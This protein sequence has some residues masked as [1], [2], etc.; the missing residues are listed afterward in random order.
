[1]KRSNAVNFESCVKDDKG[2]LVVGKPITESLHIEDIVS[3]FKTNKILGFKYHY[4]V[5]TEIQNFSKSK[6]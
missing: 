5:D 4:N 2:L 6:C 1:M 3:L